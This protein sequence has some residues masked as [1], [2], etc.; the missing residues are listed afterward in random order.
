MSLL[1]HFFK[2]CAS[3]TRCPAPLSP[4]ESGMEQCIEKIAISAIL[5]EFTWGGFPP[6]PVAPVWSGGIEQCIA[7][8]TAAA[9]VVLGG[10]D[11]FWWRPKLLVAF[12]SSSGFWCFFVPS[13]GLWW[14]VVGYGGVVAFRGF[15]PVMHLCLWENAIQCTATEFSLGLNF[16]NSAKFLSVKNLFKISKHYIRVHISF[17]AFRFGN[18]ITS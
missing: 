3:F 12:L 6:L 16:A 2:A 9:L 18:M 11:G 1:K 4:W 5:G 8:I 10:F 17:T 14:F 15:P 7:K 13:C